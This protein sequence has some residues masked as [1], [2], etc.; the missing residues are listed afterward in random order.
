MK[1][2]LQK[3]RIPDSKAFVVKELK[4]PYFDKNWH[5]HSEYQLFWVLEGRGTRFI[6]DQMKPFREGDMILTGPNLPHLW[7]N[8]QE[9]FQKN[10]RLNT[11]GIV[12]Y[13]PEDFL[14][15]SLWEKEEFEDVKNLLLK[16]RRGLEISGKTNLKLREML[17]TLVFKK[18]GARII[19]LLEILHILAHSK[20]CE[21]ITHA[22]YINTN[23]ESEKDRM[24]Q[25]YE[26][27]MENF[28]QK[29]FLAEVAAL[30]NMTESAFSRYF[31]SRMNKPF[32][33]FLSDVR[34]GHACKLLQEVEAN[35]SEICYESGFQTLSN[36]NRQFKERMGVTP[37][38]YKK[39]YLNTFS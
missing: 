31:T 10:S 20:D 9:Y 11:H 38:E 6:G 26:Y 22:G 13:F 16:S 15:G 1:Q 21:P 35:V 29:I 39:D 19:G 23:K 3:S 12:V 33:E 14:G 5:F 36:F 28:K 25:V 24:N 4:A 37:M 17:Q 30:A 34:I 18:G 27:V 2:A 32:S 7:R 8:D